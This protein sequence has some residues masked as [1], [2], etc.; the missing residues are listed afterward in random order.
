MTEH[1]DERRTTDEI[2]FRRGLRST[3]PLD[4]IGDL[5]D[6]DLRMAGCEPHQYL[7]LSREQR[8]R[9]RGGRSSHHVEAG[10]VRNGR[11]ENRQHIFD[12]PGRDARPLRRSIRAETRALPEL[13]LRASLPNEEGLLEAARLLDD[14]E[15][16]VRLIDASEVSEGCILRP[17]Q[18]IRLPV[19]RAEHNENAV[20]Q[21]LHELRTARRVLLRLNIGGGRERRELIRIARGR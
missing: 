18:I 14:D 10:V 1:G 8:I 17:G 15:P 9:I 12:R 5:Y 6:L 13:A 20:A 3:Q 2:E 16:C 11:V 4:L 19:R 7:L 21:A